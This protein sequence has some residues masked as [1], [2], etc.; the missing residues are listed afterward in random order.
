LP[1]NKQLLVSLNTMRDVPL[2]HVPQQDLYA[3][4]IIIGGVQP[5]INLHYFKHKFLRQVYQKTKVQVFQEEKF[6]Q[7]IREDYCQKFLL[8]REK[9]L[10]MQVP[11]ISV[12]PLLQA[13]S[14]KIY[15]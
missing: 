1:T 10:S 12:E 13:L 4:R 6:L 7:S 8:S 3:R 5:D 11:N 2:Q 9:T 15:R 14:E